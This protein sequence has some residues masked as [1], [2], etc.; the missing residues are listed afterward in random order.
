[1]RVTPATSSSAHNAHWY[2]HTAVALRPPPASTDPP[3]AA[4]LVQA[5]ECLSTPIPMLTEPQPDTRHDST[6]DSH[7]RGTRLAAH[8]LGA[9]S[10][11][12]PTRCVGH[13]PPQRLD[14]TPG[15]SARG[16]TPLDHRPRAPA[17][18][19]RNFGAPPQ[20]TG[21]PDPVSGAR[22]HHRSWRSTHASRCCTTSTAAPRRKNSVAYEW[23]KVCGPNMIPVRCRIR[24]TSSYTLA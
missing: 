16:R 1:M 23:R 8:T 12:R 9:T 20:P 18:R 14:R 6:A 5:R 13:S 19:A 3:V 7:H 4:G 21:R 2:A 22:K 24:Q 11:A 17:P 10:L 15:H